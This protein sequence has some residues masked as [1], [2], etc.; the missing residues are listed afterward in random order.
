LPLR[1]IMGSGV[2]RGGT[3]RPLDD[4]SLVLSALASGGACR[5]AEDGGPN[6]SAHRS[7]VIAVAYGALREAVAERLAGDRAGEVALSEHAADPETWRAPLAKALRTSGASDD[8]AVLATA[9]L[10][11]RLAEAAEATEAGKDA[12]H[13][14]PGTAEPSDAGQEAPRIEIRDAQGV[15]VGPHGRQYNN[16]GTIVE[17]EHAQ[18]VTALGGTAVGVQGGT[19]YVGTGASP[20]PASPGGDSRAGQRLAG[21]AWQEVRAEGGFAYGVQGGDMH[22]HPDRGPVYLIF[23]GFPPPLRSRWPQA[24]AGAAAR[25]PGEVQPSTLLDTRHAVVTFTGRE[26]ELADLAGWRDSEGAAWSALWLHGPGG[27]GKTR[28]AAEF[29]ARSLEAG[30][31]VVSAGQAAG[32]VTPPPGRQDLRP[33]DTRGILVV[34]DYA[35]RWPASHLAWLF[36]NA[37]FHQALPTRLL[38]LARSA[39]GWP[40]VRAA[41]RDA[42][43][44]TRD[45]LLAPAGDEAGAAGRERMFAVA[46]DCFA[47]YYGLADAGDIAPPMPLS[48]PDLGLTLAVHMAALVAVDARARGIAPPANAP[49]LSAYLLDRER[50]HWARLYENRAEGLDYDT[51]P[52]TMGRTVF[53]AALAGA[54]D[55]GAGAELLDRVSVGGRPERVL[56]D[57]GTCYPAADQATVLEPLYPDRLAEDF[58]ALA[59]PGHR[60][61]G[62][63]ADPWAAVAVSALAARSPGGAVPA[64]VPRTVTFLAAAAARWPHVADHLAPVLRADPGLAVAAGGDA[65]RT[66]AEAD[67]LDLTVLEAV[68]AHLPAGRHFDLDVGIAALA[69]RLTRDRLATAPSPTARA[70]LHQKL[71]VRLMNAGQHDEAVAEYGQA[72]QIWAEL[73]DHD[74][75]A[76]LP[77]LALARQD[78]G[79]ALSMAGRPREAL[80]D[81]AAAT[82]VLRPLAGHDPGIYGLYLVGALSNYADNLSS[83]GRSREALEAAEEATALHRGLEEA[84]RSRQNESILFE[85]NA[86]RPA[87]YVNIAELLAIAGRAAEALE[88]AE[89][90][91]TI[92]RMGVDLEIEGFLPNLAAALRTL[93]WRLQEAGRIPDAVAAGQESA[94]IYQ[95]LADASPAAY[96][97]ALARAQ[98]SL[99]EILAEAGRAEDALS[100]AQESVSRWREIAAALPAKG[101][102]GLA[103]ALAALWLARWN[104]GDADG[105]LAAWD[106]ATEIYRRLVHMDPHTYEPAL[107][108]LLMAFSHHLDW[109]EQSERVLAADRE[110]VALYRTLAGRD[111]AA[112]ESGLA[113][114]LDSLVHHLSAAGPAQAAL[115]VGLEAVGLRRQ[116]AQ[117]NPSEHEPAL[118]AALV[119]LGLR[120]VDVGRPADAGVAL[121][122]AADLHRRL[123][124]TVP[125]PFHSLLA[126]A[127]DTL[128]PMLWDLLQTSEALDVA[129]EAVQTY[130]VL[131]QADPGEYLGPLAAALDQL[132]IILWELK[133][134]PRA[135]AATEEASVLLR[136]LAQDD[137]AAYTGK[138]AR[139]LDGL[140]LRWWP[141]GQLG[142]AVAAAQEAV[143]LHRR[144]AGDDPSHL[145][146]YAEA[147]NTLLVVQAES[148]DLSD[149]ALALGEEAVAACRR[150]TIADPALL[151]TLARAL[152]T[153][154]GLYARRG[155]AR[156]AQVPGLEG[157]AISRRLAEED[158][159]VHRPGLARMLWMFAH[160]Q[161]SGPDALAAA[162]EAASIYADLAA[163]AP[164]RYAADLEGAAAV[165]ASVTAATS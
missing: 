56:T 5:D 35:D 93:A 148:G 10:V 30:W 40:A 110:A 4:V 28:L 29:A 88:A 156:Q 158:P 142:Q 131:V 61:T 54:T 34:V 164:A 31:K 13:A 66:L 112:F 86:L 43:A 27:Q 12:G 135:L 94:R 1:G 17:A 119:L 41:L 81:S 18:T 128:R 14:L 64:H 62:Y 71:A 45:L 150:L 144:M 163:A 16:V 145:L 15:Q 63:P 73:A 79:V 52:V 157:I 118:A 113:H 117:A 22:V 105:A 98:S 8:P 74:S 111:P 147:L 104:D 21:S 58:L 106:E 121:R 100:P 47:P 125:L 161:G 120:M 153:L 137:P 89:N 20:G 76:Y 77:R 133:Q 44:S 141:L 130:R 42:E 57:H 124:G 72:I 91:V 102:P 65:L 38:L 51:S 138:L 155:R 33:G 132:G 25:R 127:L 95:R 9:R 37:L 123:A 24:S 151:P 83:A 139:V 90:A 6:G 154:T 75:A 165:L 32:S 96:L 134:L 82:G 122:E 103:H 97:P 107:A 59:L 53:T 146:G 2:G 152:S 116:L 109:T 87:L 126:E 69:V 114:A 55:H 50:G 149:E 84:I 23:E 140:A 60:V 26:R 39:A 108:R 129:R 3:G 80:A 36:S 46:R 67:A 78:R 49:T 92:Y 160:T 159:A 143:D 11:L 162:R 136:R 101:L 48:S 115:E 85:Y 99:A 70:E 68:E 7:Q 19:A